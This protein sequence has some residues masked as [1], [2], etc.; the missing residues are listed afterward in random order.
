MVLLCL[1][2]IEKSN[3]GDAKH[4]YISVTGI[5]GTFLYSPSYSELLEHRRSRPSWAQ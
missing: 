3:L 1:I 4:N 2:S 5:E